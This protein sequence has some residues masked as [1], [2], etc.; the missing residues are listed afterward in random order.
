MLSFLDRF[1]IR[2]RLVAATVAML[3][4]LGVL[5]GFA[6]N[7]ISAVNAVSTEMATDTL[8][9]MQR[10]NAVQGSLLTYRKLVTKT[11]CQSNRPKT[12]CRTNLSKQPINKK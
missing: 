11:T 7:R 2:T 3:C 1:T 8:P 10:L 6:V 12:T 4:M 5:G 9:S